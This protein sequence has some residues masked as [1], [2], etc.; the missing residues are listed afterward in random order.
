MTPPLR[1]P[2]LVALALLFAGCAFD[3]VHLKQ[4]PIDFQPTEQSRSFKLRE[5]A[6]VRIATPFPVHLRSGTSWML[7]GTTEKG[8]VYDTKD[9]VLAVEGSNMHEA[10]LILS[11]ETVVG[12]LLKVE[13]T[14]CPASRPV[15]LNIQSL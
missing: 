5:Y 11:G 4:L 9:Q 10:Y 3:I 8:E 12:F 2:L 1:L 7:V 15:K 13:R 6:E 14:F